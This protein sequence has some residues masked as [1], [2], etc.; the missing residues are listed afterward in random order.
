[1]PN[2]ETPVSDIQETETPDENRP[3]IDPLF[4]PP[5][6]SRVFRIVR[7]FLLAL[8]IFA[9]LI[10][11]G[12]SALSFVGG[13]DAALKEGLEK[14]FRDYTGMN[15]TITT[16]NDLQIYP[17]LRMDIEGVS[18]GEDERKISAKHVVVGMTFWDAVFSRG[19][20]MAS[21]ANDIR[22]PAGFLSSRPMTI[23][24]LALGGEG[25]QAA[26]KAKGAYNALPFDLT[27]EM[28]T[29]PSAYGPLYRIAD[30]AAFTLILDDLTFS[31]VA[32]H[33]KDSNGLI[34]PEFSVSDKNTGAALMK[35]SADFRHDKIS[36]NFSLH[37]KAAPGDSLSSELNLALSLSREEALSG[38][39]VFPLVRDSDLKTNGVFAKLF[40]LVSRLASPE[41]S[42]LP[43]V[44][45]PQGI[46]ALTG[47]LVFAAGIS[48]EGKIPLLPAPP[49]AAPSCL[50]GRVVF[51]EG[52]A[53]LDPLYAYVPRGNAFVGKA[54]ALDL[55]TGIPT[56]GGEWLQKDLSTAGIEDI[57]PKTAGLIPPGTPCA[58]ISGSPPLK[59]PVFRKDAV[60]DL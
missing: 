27:L 40:A 11:A 15:T 42:V 4:T 46:H 18:S 31:G 29:R 5:P 37:L 22:L 20:M 3:G 12:V 51:K 2:S 55:D 47:S 49:N 36:R 52:K 39:M 58:F 26:L 30:R 38:V 32:T 10:L 60:N 14:F 57:L 33:Q 21:G 50:G 56:P 16:L 28:K 9:I 8:I 34:F 23:E 6:R 13:N 48:P 19:W 41:P 43:S 53:V 59:K 54:L 35:G 24:T 25:A 7:R 45:T 17:L 44:Q 1:M